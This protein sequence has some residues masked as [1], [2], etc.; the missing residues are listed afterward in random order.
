MNFS[1]TGF[2][3]DTLTSGIGCDSILTLNFNVVPVSRDTVDY[4]ACASELPYSWQGM[5][6]TGPGTYSDT[7][8][9][10]WGCD[11]ILTLNLSV[12]PS[13]SSQSSLTE[14]L[15]AFY[16]FNGNAED[17]T[18]NANH[19]TVYGATP[20]TDR[21]GNE[22]G[23]YAFDGTDDYI[24]CTTEVG[25]FGN[26]SRT[27]SFWAKTDVNPGS[28]QQNAVL[29]YGGNIYNSGSRFE[30]NLNAKCL[31]VG[32]DVSGFYLTK[33]FD[34]SDNDWH[35]YVVVFD[36]SVSNKMSDI[37]FYSD[38]QLLSTNCSYKGD[39]YVN[40]LNQQKL[41]IGRLFT[42]D[43]Y[44]KGSIDDIKIFDKAL[45]DGEVQMD[46]YQGTLPVQE[47]TICASESPYIFGSQQLNESGTYTETF[48]TVLGCDS[49]VTLNLTVNPVYNLKDTVAVCYNNLPYTWQGMDLTKPGTYSDTLT[50][51]MGCDSILTLYFDVRPIYLNYSEY[52]ICANELPYSW[53]G[54]DLTGPGYY[55][56]TLPSIMCCD[57]IIILNFDVLPVYRDTADYTICANELPYT[58]QGMT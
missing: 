48:S 43:R 42:G 36:N 58:W 23:A 55:R 49:V 44:F 57:S 41:N 51:G 50:T 26:A 14:N 53:R 5:S 1:T 47:V 17:Q 33:S 24:L 22:N 38:G 7:L 34:N 52:T 13:Y 19:G 30:I 35:H 11:S 10:A 8:A 40:T 25:P 15:V 21:W 20:T 16:S 2:Y 39:V 31:G 3:S 45:T 56:D 12:N 46:L 27:I 18:S 4:I 9:S 37:S 29:S 32:V 54:M 6:L 28:S